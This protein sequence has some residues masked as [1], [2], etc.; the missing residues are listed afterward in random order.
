MSHTAADRASVGVAAVTL[1]VM[2]IFK[3]FTIECAHRLPNAGADHKC[4]RLHGHS[5]QIEVHVRGEPD[6]AQG[7]VCDFAEV[8]RAF[9]P[10]YEQLDHNYLN[11]IPGLENPTSE[12]LAKWVWNRLQ[13]T[14]PGLDHIV[15]QETCTA[16]ARYDGR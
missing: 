4:A 12:L 6:P 5:M 16:G 3:I 2:E 7:W 11:D 8:K 15:V 14:L 13:P 9:Q 1:L 10:L